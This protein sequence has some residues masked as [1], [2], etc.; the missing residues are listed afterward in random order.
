MQLCDTQTHWSWFSN[1]L[2]CLFT[3][4]GWGRRMYKVNF[5]YKA[6]SGFNL[7]N[8]ISFI[9]SIY[10]FPMESNL[11]QLTFLETPMSSITWCPQVQG[12]PPAMGYSFAA[13]T[14]DGPG[15]FPFSQSTVTVNPLWNTIRN[16][17]Y[18]PSERQMAC[19][20]P[21]PILLTTGEVRDINQLSQ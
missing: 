11:P 10:L 18:G 16:L 7:N 17:V 4:R 12:C 13:G 2:F 1:D 19:H 15:A 14:T 5:L 9:T 8:F 3:Y 6:F 21:K 20:H